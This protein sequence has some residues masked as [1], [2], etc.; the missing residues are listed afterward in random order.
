[1]KP[2]H[3]LIACPFFLALWLRFR[4]RLLSCWGLLFLLYP[5]PEGFS[6]FCFSSHQLEILGFLRVRIDGPVASEVDVILFNWNTASFSLKIS[7]R[8]AFSLP[9]AWVPPRIISEGPVVHHF[10]SEVS[11]FNHPLAVLAFGLGWLRWLYLHLPN[12]FIILDFFMFPTWNQF[13]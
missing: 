3:S 8:V 2:N 13:W 11:F 6:V 7:S 5:L 1:M 12:H 10:C 4:N 9:G